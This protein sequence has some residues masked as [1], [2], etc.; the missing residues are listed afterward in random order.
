MKE[1][2]EDRKFEDLMTDSHLIIQ[3][4]TK[5]SGSIYIGNQQSAGG[6]P[7]KWNHTDEDYQK[8]YNELKSKN[9]TA[10]ICCADGVEIY[11]GKFNYLQLPLKDY[12]ECD[13]S[14][15]FGKTYDFIEENIIKGN[16]LIHCNAGCSRIVSMLMSYLMKKR[17]MKFLEAKELI[18][19]IR[20]CI[21][22]SNFD[23]YLIEYEKELLA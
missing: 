12:K 4:E 20:T 16:I 9:I 10:I 1:Y 13:I 8:V 3:G 22:A 14:Q 5:E 18:R 21:D 23:S 19:N 6:F 17:K 11:P 2:S 7:D 15:C